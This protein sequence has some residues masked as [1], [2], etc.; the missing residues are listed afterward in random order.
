MPRTAP[1]VPSSS[2]PSCSGAARSSRRL[3][4][5]RPAEAAVSNDREILNFALVLEYLQASFYTEAER[6]KTLTKG[7]LATIPSRLGAVERAHVTAFKRALGSAAVKRPAL[8]FAGT[9]EQSD[10]PAHGRGAGGSRGRRVQGSGGQISAHPDTSLRRSRSTA[11]RRA[12]PP[13]CGTCSGD[14]PRRTRSTSPSRPPRPNG[15]SPRRTSSS[16]R[17]RRASAGHRDSP[18]RSAR[19]A[20]PR[21]RRRR[22]RVDRLAADARR[23]WP[24]ALR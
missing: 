10:V 20:R 14:G 2:A 15:S 9:T 17:R 19:V 24:V 6:R 18:A 1:V 13:G 8:D 11:S 12:T 21:R 16:R 22:R 5:P 3:A 7:K 23:S 4:R